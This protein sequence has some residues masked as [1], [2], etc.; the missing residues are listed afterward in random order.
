MFKAARPI[1]T[2]PPLDKELEVV[3]NGISSSVVT[4]LMQGIKCS[5]VPDLRARYCYRPKDDEDSDMST[6]SHDAI[7]YYEEVKSC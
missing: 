1:N 5:T 7:E 4:S 3:A 6:V 2:G